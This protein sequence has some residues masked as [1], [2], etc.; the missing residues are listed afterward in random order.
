MQGLEPVPQA[1]YIPVPVTRIVPD[2]APL[3]VP[4]QSVGALVP[5]PI[6]TDG[7]AV[8]SAICGFVAII[9]IVSQVIGLACGVIGLCRIRR[10]RRVGVRIDGARWAVAGIVSSGFALLC[11]VGTFVFIYLLRDNLLDSVGSLQSLVRATQ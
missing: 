10:A 9:P 1:N 5:A 8:A 11:W 4:G 2:D 3:A 7:F 6:K